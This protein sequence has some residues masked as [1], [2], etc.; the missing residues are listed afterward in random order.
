MED[1]LLKHFDDTGRKEI[2]E[3]REKYLQEKEELDKSYKGRMAIKKEL[4]R[5]KETGPQKCL[6]IMM[7]LTMKV[8]DIKNKL[9]E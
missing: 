8:D 7:K 1:R 6:D 3:T 5:I 2:K 4:I 9:D